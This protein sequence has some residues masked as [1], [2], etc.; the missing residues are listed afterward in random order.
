MNDDNDKTALFRYGILAPL[1]S[2]SRKM[3]S[4]IRRFSRRR[5]QGLHY[6]QWGRHHHFR[7]HAGEVVLQA[8]ANMAD[9]LMPKSVNNKS[10]IEK[11]RCHGG[12]C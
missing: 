7:H 8:I 10:A 4:A 5:E 3:P 1:L 9:G 6:P 11:A 2:G 12:V